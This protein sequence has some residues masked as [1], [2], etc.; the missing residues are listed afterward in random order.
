[1]VT[2]DFV[3]GVLAQPAIKTALQ[4]PSRRIQMM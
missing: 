4:K 1:M 3:V 2:G